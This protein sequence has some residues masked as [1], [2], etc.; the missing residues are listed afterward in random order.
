[1]AVPTDITNNDSVY[2]LVNTVLAK[3]ETGGCEQAARGHTAT[4]QQGAGSEH[5]SSGEAGAATRGA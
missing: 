1:M 4:R 3:F 5:L 2:D